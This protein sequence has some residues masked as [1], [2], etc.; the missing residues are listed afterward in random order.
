LTPISISIWF[1]IFDLDFAFD[2]NL[3]P[4]FQSQFLISISIMNLYDIW[5]SR[6]LSRI[7]MISM[8]SILDLLLWS[9]YTF[10]ILILS[11]IFDLNSYSRS[12]N[13]PPYAQSWFLFLISP[14]SFSILIPILNFHHWSQ[15]PF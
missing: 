12:C 1:P 8:I 14:I 6:S 3:Y 2:P 9:R 4:W 7:S 10:S 15:S 5:G 13:P 11:P